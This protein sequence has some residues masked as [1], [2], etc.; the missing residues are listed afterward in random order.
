MDIYPEVTS[1][2]MEDR[3]GFVVSK[4]PVHILYFFIWIPKFG[5][6]R[7]KCRFIFFVIFTAVIHTFGI[8]STI[9][10]LYGLVTN[11]IAHF[12]PAALIYVTLSY[13]IY[14]VIHATLFLYSSW[15]QNKT[16]KMLK[17]LDQNGVPYSWT[18]G[19]NICSMSCALFAVS[20]IIARNYSYF[21][22]IYGDERRTLLVYHFVED[23]KLRGHLLLVYVLYHGYL[24]II[25]YIFPVYIFYICIC[26]NKLINNLET[27]LKTMNDK[28]DT[29]NESFDAFAKKFNEI[30]NLVEATDKTYRWNIG[31][32]IAMVVNN[33]ICG[34]YSSLVFSD[35]YDTSAIMM[36]FISD[37]MG[38]FLLLVMASSVVSNVRY[39]FCFSSMNRI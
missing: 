14:L 21:Q 22:Y 39:V 33:I 8:L 20:A 27:L 23:E 34:L 12:I 25:Y 11:T 17:L 31:W 35:C 18:T 16:R 38:L 28:D 13:P 1:E 15:N 7:S 3:K 4:F 32:Y 5:D 6:K 10:H 37:I 29:K 24:F 9:L 26:L 36:P 30:V 19:N 2:E